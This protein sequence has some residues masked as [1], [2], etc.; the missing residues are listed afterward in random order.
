MRTL[1]IHCW[2]EQANWPASFKEFPCLQL[3]IQFAIRTLEIQV[4]CYV[5]FYVG[6]LGLNSDFYVCTMGT[7]H[8][9]GH[10]LS[11]KFNL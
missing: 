3:L 5:S 8:C 4:Y 1:A 11:L 6:T 2:V 10:S 9:T 7:S